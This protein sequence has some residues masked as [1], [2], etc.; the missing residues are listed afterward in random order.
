MTDYRVI[1]AGRSRDP[2]FSAIAYNLQRTSIPFLWINADELDGTSCTVDLS[3]RSITWNNLKFTP[4]VTWIRHFSMR[5]ALPHQ[6]RA[7]TLLRNDSWEALVSQLASISDAAIGVAP[8]GQLQQL[9]D[10]ARLG[11]RVPR[12]IFT[13][14]SQ[15]I[16]ELSRDGRLVV[17]ALDR[18]Y[19]EYQPGQLSWFHPHVVPAS[20]WMEHWST[21]SSDIPVAVQEY[22]THY[23]EIRLYLIGSDAYAFT[24][25]KQY[26]SDIWLHPSRVTV[27]PIDPPPAALASARLLADAWN[28]R[29]GAFDFLINEDGVVFLE[30][31]VHGDWRW[32][33]GKSGVDAVSRLASQLVAYLHRLVA[34]ENRSFDLLTFLGAR[35]Y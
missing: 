26:P 6:D 32:Y 13:N 29:Y 30:V 18:H 12:T 33:E 3:A 28:L 21:N 15:K 27:R 34:G 5:S 10:A 2:E 31:N 7:T 20:Q 25:Q 17:K 16:C 9:N 22:V 4:S 14:D 8:P 35:T 1:L 24:V 19:I 23:T 11:I